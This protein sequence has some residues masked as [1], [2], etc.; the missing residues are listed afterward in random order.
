VN[1]VRPAE[2]CCLKVASDPWPLFEQGR[3]PGCS[4]KSS[5]LFPAL[6]CDLQGAVRVSRVRQAARSGVW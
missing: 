3:A 6:A 4:L 5:G 1:G 2:S